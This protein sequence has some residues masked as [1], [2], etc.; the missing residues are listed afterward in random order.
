MK[1]KKHLAILLIVLFVFT[2]MLFPSCSNLKQNVTA[3]HDKTDDE[4]AAIAARAYVFGYPLVIMDLT[5]KVGSNVEAVSEGVS[6]APINQIGHATKSPDDTFTDVVKPNVDTYYSIAWLDLKDEPMVLTV[7]ATDRYYLLPMLDAYTNVFASPGTR[8]TGTGAH[9]FLVA[10]PSF[11]GDVPKGMELIEA[12]TS[13]VWIIGRIQVN[14]PEDGAATVKNIQKGIKLLPLNEFGNE[15]Y[16]APKGKVVKEYSKI[17]PVKD[18]AEMPVQDFFT[19]MAELM[20]D[21]PPAE[22]DAEIVKEMA[23]IGIVPG[24]AFDASGFSERL[25]AQ[26]NA[27]PQKMVEIIKSSMSGS[28]GKINGWS[29]AT[30]TNPALGNFGTDYKYR[31][32]IAFLGLG[33]NLQ[34]DAAYPNTVLDAEGN[35]L[36]SKNKY[37]IHF[38]KDEIPPVNAFWS[39]TMYNEKNFLA[40]NPISR[41]AIGDRTEGLK[42]NKDGSLDIYIQKENPGKDKESNWLPAPQEGT[43]ELTMR[44]YWPKESVFDGTW[45]PVPVLKAD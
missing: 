5:K 11:R 14:S 37:T 13:M 10:G 36:T 32:L 16:T 9:T 17:I 15:N 7:P 21:N 45:K 25:M 24:K 30:M 6:A 19:R 35:Q 39:L 8:T 1:T 12:P 18:V 27:I 29:T 38:E 2:A 28:E 20:V 31:T 4:I 34:A 23:S 3:T 26:M 41:F 33:A 44:L 22:A 42:Y 43:F 40:K